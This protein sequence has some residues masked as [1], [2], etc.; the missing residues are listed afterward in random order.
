MPSIWFRAGVSLFV[1]LAAASLYAQMEMP[2]PAPELKKLDFLAGHWTA[3]GTMTPPGPPTTP[4]TK[5]TMTTKAEWLEGS[6]FLVEHS[7]GDL[8]PMG[9]ITELAVMGFDRDRKIYTYNAFSSLGEA[10]SATG[11]LD[12]DTWTWLSDEHRNGAAF[13][14][15]YTMKVLSPTSYTM[16]FEMSQDGASWA[17]VMEGK[18]TK[19]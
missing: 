2:S 4:A 18:A 14:G 5:W 8:G 11:T 6:H 10:E 17:T 16:K 7:D 9:K 3:E 12:G 19:K 1:W 13:K 15:R